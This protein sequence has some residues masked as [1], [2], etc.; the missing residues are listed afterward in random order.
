MK[1]TNEKLISWLFETKA[2]RVCSGDKPFWYTSGTIGPY[3]INTHFLYGSE[4]KANELLGIIDNARND[5][6]RCPLIVKE[7]AMH[8]YLSDPIYRGVI[9]EM[10]RYI[11][12]NIGLEKIDCVSGGERRDWFFSLII[13]EKLKKPHLVIYKDLASVMVE[14][15]I[16]AIPD[17]LKGKNILHIADLITEASSYERAWIPAVRKLG[18]GI[19]WSLA[20]VDRMQGGAELLSGEGIESH[21][22]I[23]IEE[24]LFDKALSIGLIDERQHKMVLDY[25][26]NPKESM[27][28]FLNEHPEFIENSLKGDNRTRERVKLCI[29]KDIYGLNMKG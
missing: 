7:H 6:L 18:G 29:E 13:A 26:E 4:E 11:Y 2:V 20:V 21:A 15:G 23:R 14:N 8:N 12:T 17:N 16:V 1:E 10:C 19:R 28:Q 25:I 5:I 22:M 24:D 3:Y 27:R 9:D